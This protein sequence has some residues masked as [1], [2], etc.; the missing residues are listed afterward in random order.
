MTSHDLPSRIKYTP[1]RWTLG[2]I[3][4][5]IILILAPVLAFITLTWNYLLGDLIK[6]VESIWLYLRVWAMITGNIWIGV[7][8]RNHWF[9]RA[10]KDEKKKD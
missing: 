10:Q 7:F 5:S 2:V 4:C 3:V 1:L 6:V 8:T 9:R